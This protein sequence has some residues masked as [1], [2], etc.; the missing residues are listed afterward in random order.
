[1]IELELKAVVADPRALLTKLREAGA[2]EDFCGRLIDR[3]FDFP[4]NILS[5]R[6]EVVRVREYRA[7]D[8][9]SKASLEWKGPA[10]FQLGY[11]QRE[12]IGAGTSDAETITTILSHIGLRVCRTI[13]REI[14][15]F[16]LDGATVRLEHYPRMDD[17]VEVEGDADA[18]ERAISRL[19]I[20]RTAFS[21][22][23][24]AAFV[25]RFESRTGVRAVTG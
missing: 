7:T 19:G 23:N 11:K 16:T 14:H 9:E 8:G 20:T 22:D 1:V 12:E 18:I 5:I 3:R 24:L 6:D 25:Q 10:S 4:D 17:L 13:D 21:T 15:Q 2:R